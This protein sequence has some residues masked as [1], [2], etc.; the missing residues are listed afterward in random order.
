ML[1]LHGDLCGFHV[2][3]QRGGLRGDL[4]GDSALSLLPGAGLLAQA[5]EIDAS[6]ATSGCRRIR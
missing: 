5:R 2:V 4:V 1:E 6:A 3:H